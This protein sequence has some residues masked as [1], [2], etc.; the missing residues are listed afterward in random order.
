METDPADTAPPRAATAPPEPPRFL[1]GVCVLILT[2]NEEANIGRTLE[3]LV[4]IPSIV[5]VDSGSTDKTVEII[6]RFPNARA[7]TH[8]F[9]DHASQWNFGLTGCGITAPWVLA[10]DADYVVPNSL[11]DE[12][13]A[14]PAGT[15]VS[16][17]RA[18]FRYVVQGR[19]L[20]GAL[21]PPVTVLVRRA[22]ARYIQ[23]GHT[24][25][26]QVDG[27]IQDLAGRITHDDRKPLARWFA[28]Q[29]RY[30]ALEA[31][32]LLESK[33]AGAGRTGRIRLMMGPAPLLVFFYTLLVKRCAFDG[34][35]G[36]FYA[37]QRTLVEIMIALE[38]LDRRLRR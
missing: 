25:R 30:A 1:D 19:P 17:Y 28:A 11:I 13:A 14:L 32:Y 21:Y 15:A 29:M 7:I 6:G 20:S 35:A 3:A 34:R 31:D 23:Q 16:G 5:V 18:G 37:L 4:R 22:R 26:V 33:G 38:L 10:L 27:A 2:Y 8:A 24:Q 9:A 12:I 36:W